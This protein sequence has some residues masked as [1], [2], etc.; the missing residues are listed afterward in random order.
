MTL[1]ELGAMRTDLEFVFYP[2]QQAL[3]DR[4]ITEMLLTS[5]NKDGLEKGV[6][7]GGTRRR[8]PA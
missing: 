5:D 6:V 2:P 3:E 8:L 7:D 4:G 1:Q